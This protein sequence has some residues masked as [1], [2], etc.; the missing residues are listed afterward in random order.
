LQERSGRPGEFAV[1]RTLSKKDRRY[2][3][4]ATLIDGV[5]VLLKDTDGD[6]DADLYLYEGKQRIAKIRELPVGQSQSFRSSSGKQYR[7]TILGVH[8]RTRTVRIGINPV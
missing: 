5:T 8:H 3:R 6:L 2:P 7:L 1:I 4:Q